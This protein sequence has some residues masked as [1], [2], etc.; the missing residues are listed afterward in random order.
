[1]Y[2]N[3]AF[4]KKTNLFQELKIDKDPNESLKNTQRNIKKKNFLLICQT[5][6][7]LLFYMKLCRSVNVDVGFKIRLI[8]GSY[9]SRTFNQL[10]PTR[11]FVC[12]I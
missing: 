10:L 2:L 4:P 3:L 6:L 1:M 5:D 7:C 9:A 11:I 8:Q 12:Y